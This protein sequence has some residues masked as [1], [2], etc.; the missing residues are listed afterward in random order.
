VIDL[1]QTENYSKY[2]KAIGWKVEKRGGVYY[3][4]RK[5]PFIGSVIKIQRPEEIRYKDIKLLGERYRALQIIIEPKDTNQELRIRNYGFKLSKSPYLP[6]K[7]LQIDLTHSVN[8][9][10]KD[11]HS[12]TRYNIR[13]AKRNNVQI[14]KSNEIEIFA[15]FWQERALKE[16]G[17]LLSQ[18]NLIKSIYKSFGENVQLYLAKLDN[19]ILAGLLVLEADKTSYYMY[20]G[21][22]TL[23]K[24]LFAPTLITW[25]AILEAKKRGMRVF[26]FDGIYDERFP[27]NTWKGF[28]RFKKGFGG[29]EVQ[30]PGTFV[31]NILPFLSLTKNI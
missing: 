20:A 26:D 24:K 6:T 31:K 2:I 27:I 5:I 16:R 3:F 15:N 22:N 1:R 21:S 8:K 18:K 23:G 4:I 12:K 11:M 25:E 14:L 10:L 29:R 28:T 7:T 17:M 30:Y 9:L 19:N 13:K